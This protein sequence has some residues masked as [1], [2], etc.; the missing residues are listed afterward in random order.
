MKLLFLTH[1]R[2]ENLCYQLHF[3]YAYIFMQFKFVELIITTQKLEV[4]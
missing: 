3:I 1:Q 2:Y 4:K